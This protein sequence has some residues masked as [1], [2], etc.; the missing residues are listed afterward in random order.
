MLDGRAGGVSSDAVGEVGEEGGR[1]R[2]DG[3]GRA[4]GIF[5][6]MVIA[7]SCM[8]YASLTHPTVCFPSSAFR[9]PPFIVLIPN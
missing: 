6:K 8:G 2:E 7:G 9:P 3:R 4:E 1:K 5:G